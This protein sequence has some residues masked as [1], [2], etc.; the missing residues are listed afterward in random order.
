MPQPA[1]AGQGLA[2]RTKTFH[3]CYASFSPVVLGRVKV[4]QTDGQNLDS[5]AADAELYQFESRAL[6][7]ECKFAVFS[8]AFIEK[9]LTK[10]LA[11]LSEANAIFCGQILEY[12]EETV[13]I[14][15]HYICGTHFGSERSETKIEF[16]T[17]GNRELRPRRYKES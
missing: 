4:V 6:S 11:H 14:E 15:L 12:I 7:V 16:H 17:L 8:T 5:L 10:A 2:E 13:V 1:H 3:W 9:H